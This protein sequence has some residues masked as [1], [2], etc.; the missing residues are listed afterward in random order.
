MASLDGTA[1]FKCY[2]VFG[3]PMLCVRRTG[4]TS[5]LVDCVPETLLSTLTAQARSIDQGDYRLQQT[6][7]QIWSAQGKQ[8]RL[9]AL[10]WRAGGWQG[11]EWQAFRAKRETESH[12]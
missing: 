9:A 8:V 6:P 5:R 11:E 10:T 4:R 2:E 3:N 12:A 1:G 7:M